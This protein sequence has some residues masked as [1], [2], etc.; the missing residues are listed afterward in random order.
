MQCDLTKLMYRTLCL[1][2]A[3]LLATCGGTVGGASSKSSGS[4]Y[5][6]GGTVTGLSGAVVLQNNHGDNLTVTGNVAF[7]FATLVASGSAY[8]VAVLAHPSGQSCS[9]A[10]GSG[11]VSGAAVSNVAVFQTPCRRLV[12]RFATLV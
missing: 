1:C 3:L 12:H 4:N 11:T 9:V 7:T 5:T 10:N 6:V 8:S 2:V